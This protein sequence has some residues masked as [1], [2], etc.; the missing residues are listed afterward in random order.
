VSSVGE[1]FTLLFSTSRPPSWTPSVSTAWIRCPAL[2]EAGTTRSRGKW[3]ADCWATRGTRTTAYSTCSRQRMRS[4]PPS[5]GSTEM[6]LG[7]ER[8]AKKEVASA[9]GGWPEGVSIGY[10]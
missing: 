10:L 4:V 7:L 2:L 1:V 8:R 6:M 9:S 3:I 5:T